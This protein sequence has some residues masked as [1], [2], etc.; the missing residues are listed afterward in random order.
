MHK[1]EGFDRQVDL[2]LPR[3]YNKK[4]GYLYY[5][6]FS[7]LGITWEAEEYDITDHE[8]M[9]SLR[10]VFM[11]R[12]DTT[13]DE[14]SMYFNYDLDRYTG[15]HNK[16]T[17]IYE[18]DIVKDRSNREFVVVYSSYHASWRLESYND[19]AKK[20]FPYEFIDGRDWFMDCDSEGFNRELTVIG[21]IH[22]KD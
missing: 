3:V 5:P 10:D 9:L 14:T 7:E 16:D 8:H 4:D 11:W 13:T 22:K 18:N 1:Q 12:F 19:K 2:V 20:E 15:V 6:V 17:K 21:N